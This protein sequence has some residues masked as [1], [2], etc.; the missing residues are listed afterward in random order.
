MRFRRMAED[1]G[2]RSSHAG[3]G[4]GLRYDTH[5][6]KGYYAALYREVEVPILNELFAELSRKGSSL[7]DFACGTGRIT[8]V[9]LPHFDRVAGVDVSRAMLDRARA[10]LPGCELIEQDLTV[11]PLA[12]KFDIVTAFRFF[13]NAEDKLRREA[14][15][16]IR[17]Q[18]RPDGYLVCNVHMNPASLTGL[19]YRLLGSLRGRVLHN[20]LSLHA[21]EALLREN[22]FRVERV[23]WYGIL[24]RPGHLFPRVF[25]RIVGPAERL[26]GKTGFSGRF[27]QCFI[28]VATIEQ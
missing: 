27:S 25:D 28:V 5:Y 18:L 3:P 14:L 22:G 2:Y 24:P 23:V 26:F 10:R 11:R 8:R 12:E 21:F 20:T 17:R 4:Y 1:H 19:V 15:A 7:L 13:L 6:A 9:A 16:A